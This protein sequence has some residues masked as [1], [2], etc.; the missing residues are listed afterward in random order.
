M[1]KIIAPSHDKFFETQ[2]SSLDIFSL[3]PLNDDK[4]KGVEQ[5]MHYPPKNKDR[6][7]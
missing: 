2:K 3:L 6:I 4:R 7:R 1:G 5:M